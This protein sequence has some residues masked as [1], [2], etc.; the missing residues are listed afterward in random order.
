MSLLGYLLTINAII[1]WAL[2]SLVYKFCLGK[3]DPKGNLLFRLVCVSISTFIFSLFFGN[4]GFFTDFSLRERNEYIIACIIS[5]LSV[6]IGDLMYFTSLKKI[7]A[8]RAYPITQLSLIFVYPFAFFFFGEEITTSVLIGGIFILV[9]V[10]FL[11]KK[12]IESE[13]NENIIKEKEKNHEDPE[14]ILLGVILALG[15]AFCWGISIVAFHQARIIAGD[16]FVTNFMRIIFATLFISVLGIFQKEYYSGFKFKKE[17]RR[18][19]KY[20]ALIGIAGSISLGLADSLFYMAIELNGLVLTAT[21]TAN[22]PM[23]QLILSAIILKEKLR[24][25]FIIAVALIILGN[26]VILGLFPIII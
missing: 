15:G 26:L 21:I 20:Y 4:Y 11:S 18:D 14:D 9:S 7:D 1:T 5:G 6:T 24:K 12:D 2:A 22:T 10:F 16:V 3:T 25:K 23:V 8:S 17:N 19:L 13:K